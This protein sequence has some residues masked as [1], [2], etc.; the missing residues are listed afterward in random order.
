MFFA[1][2]PL[3]TLLAIFGVAAA[4]VVTLYILKL[5]RRP[6]PV[7]FAGIWQQILRDKDATTLFSQLKRLLSLLLQLALLALLVLA[8]GDPR[9]TAKLAEG[10]SLVVLVDTSASMKATDV[11]PSRMEAAKA[12]LRRLVGSL[13]GADRM[14]IARM[15]AVVTPLSTM[16]SDVAELQLAVGR[17]RATDTRADVEAALRFAVDTLR[18][19]AKPE[20]VLISD[21]AL[22]PALEDAKAVALGNAQ[23]RYVPIGSRGGNVAI[24][25]FSA[26]RYPLDKSRT[27]VLLEVTNTNTEPAEVEL[28]LLGDG[29]VVDLTR[30]ALKPGERLPRFYK[31][32]AGASRTLEAVIRPSAGTKDVL[33][34][35]DRA[36]AVMPERRRARVLVVTEG[37]TYLEAALLLDEYLDVSLVAPGRYPVAGTFDVTIFDRVAKQPIASAGALLYLSPPAEGSPVALGKKI[38]WFGFDTWDK[39]HPIVRFIA[40]GD[41]QV[42][43]GFTF[44]PNKEHKVIG[45]SELGPILVSGRTGTHQFVALGF[46]PRD[47]DFVLRVAWPLFVLNTINHFVEEET[48]YVSSFKTGDVWNVPAPS[49]ADT[50]RLK[51]PSGPA[52]QIPVRNGRAVYL[53]EQ[54]GFYELGFGAAERVMFAANLADP[55]ESR[56]EPAKALALN[57]KPM[58]KLSGFTPGVRRELWLYLLA[59]V[60]VVSAVE[61]F[62]YHRRVTV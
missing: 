51:P 7:P 24:T 62:T 14:L 10:R 33:P 61:W 55:E 36:F 17:I 31:D 54:A 45:A 56:I 3:S 29:V 42:A 34:A 6:V 38:E 23:L 41:I 4:A 57:G 44:K 9:T 59:A 49:R 20:I 13:G 16:S 47:S 58:A 43:Q 12:E 53:G 32:L 18:G 15:G 40:L 52:E 30:L 21:G 46:D 11:S 2:L 48:G 26:R 37:N 27:E 35:D 1:G 5:R 28:S 39:K 22:G 25:A 60:A 19:A 8:L 50:A